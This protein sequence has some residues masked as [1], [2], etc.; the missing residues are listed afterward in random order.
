ML[1]SWLRSSGSA[2]R[3]SITWVP[4]A[5]VLVKVRVSSPLSVRF[6]SAWSSIMRPPLGP[7]TTEQ[8]VWSWVGSPWSCAACCSFVS[9]SWWS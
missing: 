7:T 8:L 5:G 2:S 4:S 9:P 1:L 3:R 6:S